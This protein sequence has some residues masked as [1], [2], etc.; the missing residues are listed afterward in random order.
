MGYKRYK[1]LSK[2]CEVCGNPRKGG[3]LLWMITQQNFILFSKFIHPSMVSKCI[4]GR[5]MH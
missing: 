1:V 2:V 3:H 4:S 5:D